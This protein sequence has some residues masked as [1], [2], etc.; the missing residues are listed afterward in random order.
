[1]NPVLLA[2]VGLAAWRGAQ[3]RTVSEGA[4][5]GAAAAL[6][7]FPVFLL[8]VLVA[9]GAWRALAWA[10]CTAVVLTLVPLI[11]YP[12]AQYVQVLGDWW[13]ISGS[14]E[15]PIRRH[16]QSLFAMLGRYGSP[17][18]LLTW[19]PIPDTASPAVHLLWLMAS[20]VLAGVV[21]WAIWSWKARVDGSMPVAL[22]AGLCVAVVLSPIAWEHYWLLL[23]P[24][25]AIA[26]EPPSGAARW[27][28]P[29]FWVAAV[30][31]SAIMP[32][33][34]G[35]MGVALARGLSARTWGALVLTAATLAAY[36]ALRRSD[37]QRL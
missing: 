11:R 36:A 31:T 15:W 21:L 25:F 9:R 5:L 20:V 7:V 27:A 6:K 4:W 19:G 35:R 34:V 13:A 22:A 8:A 12:P 28:R 3:G 33:T 14:G 24:A 17:A 29:A 32:A 10:S 30:L 16:N 23:W 37:A 1:M 26:Y 2:A 18:D